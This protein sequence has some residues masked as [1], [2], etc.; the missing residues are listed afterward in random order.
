MNFTVTNKINL[1]PALKKIESDE[2]WTF[3]AKEWWRQY[4]DDV[5]HDTNRLRQDVKIKPKQIEHFVPYAAFI[6]FGLKM[7]DPKYGVGGFTPDNGVTWFSRKGVKKKRGGG[8]LKLKN[9][10]RLWD[11]KA[12]SEKKDLLLISSMQ[13]WINQNL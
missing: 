7:V 9:G 13:K 5:P 3:S 8:M 2:L 11:Q 12:I 4:Y 6:Y 10:S 1:S